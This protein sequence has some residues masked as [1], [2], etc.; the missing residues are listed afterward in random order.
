MPTSTQAVATFLPRQYAP[1]QE[2]TS[3]V[4][5]QTTVKDITVNLDNVSEIP[6]NTSNTNNVGISKNGIWKNA[7]I[8]LLI[9]VAAGAV[10]VP[11]ALKF[12]TTTPS[13]ST[14]STTATTATT[15]IVPGSIAFWS[16]DN[17]GLDLYNNY[18]GNP[19]GSPTYTTSF[20][21]YGAAINL[22]RSS[23]QYISITSRQLLMNSSSFTIEAWIYPISFTGLD[24]GIFGQCQATTTNLCLHF[25]ARNN[26]LY[27][28]FYFNDIQGVTT[29]TMNVWTH[30]ACVYNAA[31][32]TQ[33][34]WLNGVLDG[35]R[36]GSSLYQGSSG[37]TTIGATFNPGSA[38]GFNGYMDQVSYIARAKN[39]TE[40]L[41]DATLYVYYSFDSGSLIDG[42]PNGINGT[43][44]GTITIITGR[45][46]QAIQFS[47]G[48]YVSYTYAPFYFL[49]IN[50]NPFRSWCVHVLVMSSTG[51]INAQLWNGGTV[52]ASGPIL[53]LN[54]WTHIGYTYSSTNGIRLYING[55]QVATTGAISFA[56]SGS[57]MYI[58]FGNDDGR[59]SYCTPNYGGSFNG[60]LDE[61]YLYR[62]ELTASQV[63]ALANP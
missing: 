54:S 62:R 14:T 17:N 34:V 49:G 30:V 56:A 22:V 12:A 4:S 51:N 23:S 18:N 58:I 26:Q 63:L 33:Q 46:N 20:L 45:V 55:A 5:S 57:P 27:C 59:T 47:S 6:S 15:T 53:P 41:N 48:A 40:I 42:G 60:A 50:N 52:G 9:T 28:A 35:S 13:T 3:S 21:G 44:S 7:L 24:Y 16:L 32:L 39:D 8:G 31:T 61:F 2:S 43:A 36:T 19:V 1:L 10:A 29:L 38:A 11:L 25:M 37:A